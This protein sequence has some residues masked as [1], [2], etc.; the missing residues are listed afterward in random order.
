M[1]RLHYFFIFS[2]FA[3]FG[4]GSPQYQGARWTPLKAQYRERVYIVRQDGT[5]ILDTEQDGVFLRTSDGSD[6]MFREPVA[7]GVVI[8]P[9]DAVVRDSRRRVSYNLVY[10]IK[11]AVI[12]QRWSKEVRSRLR[13]PVST[14]YLG[15]KVVNGVD[16][17]GA[18][19]NGVNLLDGV[20]WISIPYDI[21]M[22]RNYHYKGTKPGE[23]IELISELY[24]VKLGQEPDINK[25]QI[26]GDFE[27]VNPTT[28]KDPAPK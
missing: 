28:S 24:N 27:V 3:C 10:G 12:K 16:C 26:P 17:L 9:G 19:V 20:D 21:T 8:G 15:K 23:T 18:R 25:Y 5:K 2:F 11:K 13:E 1:A 7:R 22:L 6:V 4:C 14:R